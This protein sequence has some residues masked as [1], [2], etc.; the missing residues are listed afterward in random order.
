MTGD[1]CKQILPLPSVTI[2][3]TIEVWL[4]MLNDRSKK[5]RIR[6]FPIKSIYVKTILWMKNY[7]ISI[8]ANSTMYCLVL[9]LFLHFKLYLFFI[10]SIDTDFKQ[11]PLLTSKRKRQTQRKVFPT[12][13]FWPLRLNFTICKI[14]VW[15]SNLKIWFLFLAFSHVRANPKT[16][17]W[18]NSSL[19]RSRLSQRWI[20]FLWDFGR[21]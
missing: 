3:K 14:I 2:I 12:V 9:R 13:C 4:C 15:N 1:I 20:G 10:F 11:I 18:N 21:A 6:F 5:R 16:S 8:N 17:V 7:I 19:N